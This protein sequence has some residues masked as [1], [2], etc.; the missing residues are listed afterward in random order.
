MPRNVFGECFFFCIVH[1][2]NTTTLLFEDEI[3][4]LFA[5]HGLSISHLHGQD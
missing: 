4:T 2:E 3:E 5:K 1:V